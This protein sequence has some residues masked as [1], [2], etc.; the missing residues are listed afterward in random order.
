MNGVETHLQ[1]LLFGFQ[2]PCKGKLN[3][4]VTVS[5]FYDTAHFASVTHSSAAVCHNLYLQSLHVCATLSSVSLA[6]LT[7]VTPAK[8]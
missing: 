3:A 7:D 4:Q 1:R 2:S 6:S 5:C 8:K